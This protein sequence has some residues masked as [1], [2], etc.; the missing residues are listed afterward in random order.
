[1]H[2]HEAKDG[3]DG[4]EPS[5]SASP[6][7]SPWASAASTTTTT[8][9]H[10][11]CSRRCSPPRSGSATSARLAARDPHPRGLGRHLRRPRGRGRPA[12]DGVPLLHRRA[13]EARRVPRHRRPPVLRRHR[14]VPERRRHPG[15][16]AALCPL[17][18][19]LVETDCPVPGTR[20]PPG[21]AQPSRP[22]RRWSA[23]RLPSSRVWLPAAVA[24]ATWANAETLFGL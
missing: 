1:M 22:G 3:I 16:G 9:R 17:D 13:G 20:A 2:P 12:A 14:D 21:Q 10:G 6:R 4:L 24:E 8:T 7:S 11:P 18:R 23:R 19:L 5:C 15:G